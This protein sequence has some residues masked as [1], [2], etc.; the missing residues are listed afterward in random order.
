MIQFLLVSIIQRAPLLLVLFG[1]IAFAIARSKRHPRVSQLTVAAL[2]FY[3]I[4]LV[5]LTLVSFSIP[6]LREQMHLSYAAANALFDVANV[7]GDISFAIIIVLL[8]TAAFS[9]RN[10][11][12]LTS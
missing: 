12:G 5:V 4:K 3:V 6:R 11:S 9:S 1:G 2:A 10:Q 7:V 8:V